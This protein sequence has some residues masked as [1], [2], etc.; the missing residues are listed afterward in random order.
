MRKGYGQFCPVA[1]AAEVIG[2]RWN[3]LVLREMLYGNRYFND[4]SR[5][6]PLMSRA[7]LVQRLKELEKAGVVVSYEKETGQGYEYVLTPA[8]EALRPLIEA[9]GVWAQQWGSEQIAP[10]DLDDAL[11]MWG[12]RRRINLEA[13]AAQKMVL[14]FDFSGLTKGRKTHRSWWVVI[15]DK[16]VD[17]CQK[18]PGFK[19]D[20]LISADLSAFTHVWMGYTHLNLAL[21]QGT[22]CFEGNHDLVRQVPTWLYL[23][24]EWRYGMGIDNSTLQLMQA[25]KPVATECNE[26]S[27]A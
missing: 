2:D 25:N 12:M 14:Q 18:D 15:E 20:V 8:G 9:M 6:V 22:I 11:L 24:G 27:G 10:E 3:P 7:L 19:V 26:A 17:V 13:V 23:N 5:G 4:I 16:Q 21:K 1:K